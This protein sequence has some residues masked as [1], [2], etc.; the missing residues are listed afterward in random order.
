MRWHRKTKRMKKRAW[1]TKYSRLIYIYGRYKDIPTEHFRAK[2]RQWKR[3]WAKKRRF[4]RWTI[5]NPVEIW[6]MSRK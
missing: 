3:K 2:Y 5:D 1:R 4:F 6:K